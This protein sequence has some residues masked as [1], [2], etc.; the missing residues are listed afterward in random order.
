VIR[1][2]ELVLRHRRWVIALWIAVFLAGGFASSKLSAILS[3]TFSVPGTAS[4]QVRTDLQQHFGDRSDGSFTIIFELPKGA[5]APGLQAAL[6]AA[7]AKAARAVPG[8]SVGSFNVAKTPAGKTL[9]YGDVNSALHLAQAKGYTDK[10]LAAVGHPAGVAKVYVT[11]A[12][13]IQHDLDPVFNRDLKHGELEIAVP[14]ALLVLLAVFGFSWAVTIPLIFAGCSIAGTLGIVYGVASIWA[15]PTYAT[16]LVQ[17][18]GLGIAVDYSLLIVYRFREEL[19]GGTEVNDAVV[20][21]M[22]TAGRAVV[23]SGIAVA[24]GLAL[25]VAMPLPFIRMLG[26]AGFLIPIVSIACA[27]TLQPV[28]LSYYG[29]RGVKRHR[30]LP[31]RPVKEGDGWWARLARSI[32]AR[33]WVYLA[34]GSG[35]LILM[36]L[37]AIRLQVTPGSTFGIPRTS[38]SVK[39]FDLLSSA[40]GPG[41]VSPS[42]ILVV[43]TSG[44][45]L[46][47]QTQAAIGRLVTALGKDP[48]VAKVYTGLNGH[49]VDASRRYEQILVAGR[50]DYGFPQSQAFVH[51]LRNT[52]I[53]AAA[54]PAGATVLVGGGPGQ[55]V[56]FLHQ[57]YTYF[58]PL[59][60]AVLVLT[61]FL[62]MRAFRSVLLP[63]KAV[64]LNLLS[65]AAAYGMLVLFFRYGLGQSLFGLYK[66]GQVEG[67]IPIFLFAM[68]F[69]LSMDYE[70]FLVTRMREAWDD[71]MDNVTAVSFG[72]ERTGRIITAAAIIMCAAFSG[73][74]A[75]SIVGLQEFGLGLAV[76]IFVD[77]TIVRCLLVPS[78]MAI[79]GRW[80]WWLPGSLAR[81]VRV[82]PSPLDAHAKPVVSPL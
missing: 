40:I 72:L 35:V 45:V 8:G 39:G 27:V 67:W 50:H 16:N 65:V 62:L 43:G 77:A 30:I 48:E 61:Y 76:A 69:G 1:W 13:A 79:L 26:V 41:A 3:N 5:A 59:I 21:T 11:G 80:N 32:M 73:F 64:L 33:P 25:L 22:Q 15:T 58:V 28:L 23:F 49:F 46:A 54:F 7:V 63:L 51:R 71:G 10:V 14:I 42:Q 24:L 31:E 12:A 56:D 34:A 17:L 66:F 81:I 2:T 55:G 36:A 57:A 68:L 20:R 74:V 6:T 78:M 75:G 37:P 19:A 60:A 70:V 29:R 18:I 47:T 82:R 38:Q 44:S 9:V 4:E 53:P 52:L